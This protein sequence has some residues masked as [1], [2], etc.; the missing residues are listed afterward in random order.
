MKRKWSSFESRT[1]EKSILTVVASIKERS[2][3]ADASFAPMVEKSTSGWIIFVNG[4]PVHWKTLKQSIT[5]KSTAEAEYIALSQAISDGIFLRSILLELR[6]D[7]SRPI[8]IYEDNQ[9]AIQIATNP[10][11]KSKVKQVN[12][13][14]HFIRYYVK[15]GIVEITHIQSKDQVADMFT[16]GLNGPMFKCL[17][18]KLGMRIMSSEGSVDLSVH[19]KTLM[20]DPR[21]HD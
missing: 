5:A 3:Y 11:Y 15:M 4:N 13:H 6:I 7:M 9:A 16:K 18:D 10:V 17:K 20:K 14:Y 2:I 8:K 19:S 21:S 12:V 1:K